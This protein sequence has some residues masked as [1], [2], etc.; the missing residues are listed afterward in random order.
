MDRIEAKIGVLAEQKKTATAAKVK[1]IDEQTAKLA[2]QLADVQAR[3]TDLLKKVGE[4]R[5]VAKS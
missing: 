2:K 3:E 5:K 4:E 1:E